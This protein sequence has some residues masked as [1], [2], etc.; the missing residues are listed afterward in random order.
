MS[1]LFPILNAYHLLYF[2]A[3]Y[4]FVFVP[5]D[6]FRTIWSSYFLYRRSLM[7]LISLLSNWRRSYPRLLGNCKFLDFPI[8][9]FSLNTIKDQQY[10]YWW[11]LILYHIEIYLSS[12]CY[13][14]C[15]YLTHWLLSFTQ[16]KC[17]TLWS[18]FTFTYRYL[19]KRF[20]LSLFILQQK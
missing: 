13:Y 2:F 17:K 12:L 14:V 7:R 11:S 1:V 9:T 15:R 4:N 16:W 10:L 3:Y 18:V 20:L 6:P 5:V 8:F 19:L